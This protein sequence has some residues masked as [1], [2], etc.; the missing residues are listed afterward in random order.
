MSRTIIP[1]FQSWSEGSSVNKIRVDTLALA[2]KEDR[3]EIGARRPT[4]GQASKLNILVEENMHLI[5]DDAGVK[6]EAISQ[7][8]ERENK[9]I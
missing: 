2:S 1:L 3:S 4:T 7:L 9:F 6:L 5:R 8:A